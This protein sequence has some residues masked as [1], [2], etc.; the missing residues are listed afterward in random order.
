MDYSFV[1]GLVAWGSSVCE[2]SG[3][4]GSPIFLVKTCVEGKHHQEMYGL[5]SSKDRDLCLGCFINII[6]IKW[7]VSSSQ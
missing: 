6:I 2:K 5:N 1:I 3:H 7:L 4:W